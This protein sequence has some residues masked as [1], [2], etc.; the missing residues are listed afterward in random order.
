MQIPRLWT[1]C[2]SIS[3]YLIHV[4]LSYLLWCADVYTLLLFTGLCDHLLDIDFS[5][6]LQSNAVEHVWSSI[7]SVILK[8]MDIYIPKVRLKTSKRPRW[9]TPE[10]KHLKNRI[11]TVRRKCK[12]HPTP[13]NCSKLLDLENILRN[14][15][16]LAK[17][18]YEN[19]LIK[20]FCYRNSSK[21]FKYI[22][23]LTNHRDIPSTVTFD[24][25]SAT[26]DNGKASLFN[27]FFHSVFTSSSFSL[28]SF[29]DTTT[30]QST[31]SNISISESDVYEALTCLNITKSMGIDGIGPKIWSHCA[32]ALYKPIHHLFILSLSNLYIP[33]DWR[34]H[35]VI[36]IYKSGDKSSVK[37]YRPISLLCTISKVLEKIIYNKI[38]SFVSK[39]LSP[40]QFGFRRQ[41]STLQQL[42]LF[43]NSIC[44]SLNTKSQTDVVYLDFKKAFDSVAHNELLAKLWHFGITGNLWLWFKCYLSDRHHCVSLNHC[45]S[46]FLP[47]ISGVPQGSILGPLMFLIF[48]NDLPTSVVSSHIYLFADDTKCLK[49]IHSISD[50][51]SL[52]RDLLNLFNWS[53][54]WNLPF[55]EDK[56]VLLS[57]SANNLSIPFVYNINGNQIPSSTYH[58]DLG[59]FISQDLSWNEHLK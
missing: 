5:N 20:K 1:K 10:I 11:R 36:P 49:P 50:C 56:C 16:L 24:S 41:H 9:F 37:N 17:S 7:K 33:K 31:I 54:N 21:L 40:Y 59:V 14:K 28:P 25:S 32:L 42:L 44:Q 39:S 12:Y 45:T 51:H 46:D 53:Q 4:T 47:V 38:I 8:A 18:T 57:F 43:V 3:N 35:L 27:N 30:P 58:K 23:A 6:C 34:L 26:S 2:A 13:S 55:N 48:V 22:S 29:D 19:E 52:Q 15:V